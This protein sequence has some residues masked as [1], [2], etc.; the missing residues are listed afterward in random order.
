MKG[1]ATLS[2]ILRFSDIRADLPKD[3]APRPKVGRDLYIALR[4]RQL[5]SGH[6]RTWVMLEGTQRPTDSFSVRTGSLAR[7]VFIRLETYAGQART[8]IVTDREKG[9]IR[10]ARDSA[11]RIE[12]SIGYNGTLRSI[13]VNGIRL[14]NDRGWFVYRIK[15]IMRGLLDEIDDIEDWIHNL[16]TDQE[17]VGEPEDIKAGKI[18]KVS[19]H[20]EGILSYI[21]GI[22]GYVRTQRITR[23]GMSG[24]IHVSEPTSAKH[25]A[26]PGW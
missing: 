18:R 16:E 21:R 2:E 10:A 22:G 26:Y 4:L 23:R 20:E 13:K 8:S 17:D 14:M 15:Q 7:N 25:S 6:E 1:P 9:K 3:V 11:L 12:L 19:V 5:L 24:R